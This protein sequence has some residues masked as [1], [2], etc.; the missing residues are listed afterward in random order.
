MRPL[1]ANPTTTSFADTAAEVV[2]ALRLVVLR[3]L[4]GAD[5]RLRAAGQMRDDHARRQ[6]EG[7][8]H[9]RRVDDR[10]APA[11][12]GTDVV[13]R[14]AGAHPLGRRVDERRELRAGRGGRPPG[15]TASA[16]LIMTQ[17]FGGADQVEVDGCRIA[18][19]SRSGHPDAAR[20]TS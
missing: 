8:R 5:E 13:Q 2:R 12:P 10:D 11:R 19:L 16:S 14:A 3:V 1:A 6:A 7:R 15:T 9:L 4:D 17:Q 18:Q 20:S